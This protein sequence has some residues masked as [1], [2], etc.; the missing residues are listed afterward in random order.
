[1]KIAFVYPRFEKFLSDNPE[2][3]SGLSDYFLGDFTTPPSLGIPIL[4]SLTPESHEKILIDDNSGDLVDYKA[5]YD[6]IAIN[7]FTP[8]ASRAFEIADGFRAEGVKV[9]MGG[10][11]PSFM[12]ELCLEHC[13]SVCTSE[14]EPVWGL[15]LRDAEHNE[16]K[17]VYRGGC[18]VD[19]DS[20]P[21]PDRSIFYN[22]GSYD[23]EE[24]LVQVTRGCMYKCAMCAIP[25]HMGTRM[26]FRSVERVVEEI[27]G[28][29][30]ENV[31]L[32][33]DA[34]FFPK[35]CVLDYS[36]ELL[37]ALIP[38]NKKY[39]VSS[40]AALNTDSGFLDLMAEAGVK[41]FYCT[42]NVDPVS[43]KA[44]QG[45]KRSVETIVELVK[46]I[47]G[48][49][50]RFFG[51]CAL[52][53]DWDDNSIADR[54]LD[55][56][57]K[58]GI[59]TSEFFIFT[60]YPGSPQWGRME[61][62]NRIID[63]DWRHYNGAHV[64]CKPERMSSDEL[65]GEFIK[66]WNE[67]YRRLKGQHLSNLE[68]STWEEGRQIIGK[69]L[70]RKGVPGAAAVTGMGI[71]SPIGCTHSEVTDNLRAGRHGLR[72][73]KRFDA[74]PFTANHAGE[75]KEFRPEDYLTEEELES[76]DDMYLIYSIAA[77]RLALEDAGIGVSEDTALLAATCN[78]GLLSGE[79]EYKWKHG[80][81]D[82]PF[83]ERINLQAQY[84]GYGKALAASL[85]I[86]EGG[87]IFTTAC[88]STTGALDL[89]KTLI[90]RGDCKRVLVGGADTLSLA[91]LAGFDGL[92][93]TSSEI[94]APFS[95][96]TGLNVGEGAGFWVVEEMETALLRNA[97]IH[98]RIDGG[99]T[100][101]DAYHPTT[102]D[103]RGD[104]VMR[105]LS[106]ALDESGLSI[107][108]IGYLNA[109]ATGTE[110]NDKAEVKGVKKFL[111]DIEIPVVALKSFFGHCMGSTGIIEATCGVLAMNRGFIPPTVNYT[112]PRPGC[113][114]DCV[115]NQARESDYNAFISSNYAFG[116]NNAAVVI[117]AWDSEIKRNKHKKKRVVI[118]GTG[119]VTSIGLSIDENLESLRT[120][121]SGLVSAESLGTESVESELAGLIKEYRARDI[122]RRLS[123][124]GISNKIS[125]FA[126]TSSWEALN[127]SGI[128]ISRRNSGDYGVV[129]GICN[130]SPE[131]AHM[132][133]VFSTEN[134][135][136]DVICFSNITANSVAG[137]VSNQLVLKGSNTTLSPG[138]HAG[139]QALFYAVSDVSDQKSEGIVVSC[140]DEVYPQ[141]YYNYNLLGFLY[142]G[143]EERDY[144]IRLN[145][146]KKKVL[147]EGSAS[148]F[149]ETL[150]T[151]EQRGAEI[152]GEILG[153]GMTLDADPF[154]EQSLDHSGMIRAGTRALD[155]SG[156]MGEDID[157]VVWGPQ[158]NVQDYKVIG[159]AQELL[160]KERIKDIPFIST[161]L[162]TGYIESASS[163][164]AVAC[165]LSSLKKG[166]G[167]WDSKTEDVL[168]GSKADGEIKNILVLA[169]SDT[170]YN[171]S[172]C[173]RLNPSSV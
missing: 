135:E 112:D 132:D 16:L 108:E 83:S 32:A 113:E 63:K 3:D 145:E 37:K 91:N 111:G 120:G 96:P 6:L 2:L 167:L 119:A 79:E 105:T 45:D 44:L 124:S 84:Y 1:M 62:Q 10:F 153:Y 76:Y 55:L 159:A 156:L 140:S 18:R 155:D 136:A 29:K 130:G 86:K 64:V 61:R 12:P 128:R 117:S 138:H 90:A 109:H 53:R 94:T 20:L 172:V 121:R 134:N 36:S 72:G 54:I 85:G 97:R 93:A 58:A 133:R 137:W 141:T 100:S 151:A 69:P 34:L 33:D 22:K 164:H 52:G 19:L 95:L 169:G 17:R 42:M 73:I 162:Y 143:D 5:G 46:S 67:F 57:D 9:V 65:Y 148:L 80:K 15:I 171:Y 30:Y 24:D 129:M 68:P 127:R 149:V 88:S 125:R 74:S 142:S 104:G 70:Q 56:Y 40:T 71:I 146:R 116:G 92:K 25:A 102:P 122:D 78:G 110:A 98:A 7:C 48:R 126:V 21:T 50:I 41:N 38:L 31:Y 39:F 161:S 8:Q 26:R 158:G 144:R 160:G 4:S 35:R 163:L 87:W 107:S 106:K 82:I 47:E 114:I 75:L 23:W 123:F 27:K 59:K 165:T 11:F 154:L 28:L 152:F 13:D 150:D 118:T 77:A 168:P 131:T 166:D 81:S 101:S 139:L 170:G 103:P 147:G 14:S 66:V 173:I 157:A 43:I 115:P 99:A 89:A 51:S 49:G 60:P